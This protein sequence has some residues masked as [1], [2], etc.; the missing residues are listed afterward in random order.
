MAAAGEDGRGEES[1]GR[2][3]NGTNHDRLAFDPAGS[4]AGAF[5][6]AL[7]MRSTS[8][9][10]I[11]MMKIATSV[12]ASIPVMTTVPRMRRDVAPAPWAIQSGRQPNTNAN[13]V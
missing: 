11:G 4:P 10:S 2:N 1:G 9:K 13:D 5:D 6:R 12:A 7:A 3:R 8:T